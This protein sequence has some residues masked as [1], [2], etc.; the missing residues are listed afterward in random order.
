MSRRPDLGGELSPEVSTARLRLWIAGPAEA[1]E[2]LRHHV[3][4]REHLGRWAPPAPADV[5]TLTYWQSRCAISRRDC[6]DGRAV[7]FAMAWRSEPDRIIGTCSF[8]DIVRGPVQA[9]QLGYGLDWREQGKGVMTEALQGA[10]A[11]AF[12]PLAIHR[13]TASYMPAN[14]RSGKLLERLGFAIEG[15]ARAALFID[16]AWR[17]HVLAALINPRPIPP[18][19]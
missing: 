4:N 14:A 8:S 19:R 1:A 17:D 7:R 9:C 12:G 6:L 18:A 10:I 5:F 2:L 3:D 16:G 13:I 15:V 11:F